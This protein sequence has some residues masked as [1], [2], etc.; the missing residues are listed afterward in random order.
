M[1]LAK[2]I[3]ETVVEAAENLYDLS[4]KDLYIN[5][6]KKGVDIKEGRSTKQTIK[7]R[8]KGY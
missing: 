7:W 2:K 6:A 8:S 1:K 5:I 3:K 4:K